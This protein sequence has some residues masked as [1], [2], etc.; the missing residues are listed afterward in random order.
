MDG[1]N[2]KKNSPVKREKNFSPP[3]KK[4]WA[5]EKNIPAAKE[6]IFYAAHYGQ[7]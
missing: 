7:P 2:Q 1:H 4:I 3:Q 6:K 5:K